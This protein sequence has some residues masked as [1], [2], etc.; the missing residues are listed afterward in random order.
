[1]FTRRLRSFLSTLPLAL[2]LACDGE[3]GDSNDEAAGTEDDSAET[4]T[5]DE[6]E[7]G[8]KTDA[9]TLDDDGPGDFGSDA[10]D[11]GDTGLTGCA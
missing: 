11:D 10:M 2:V 5:G 9:G 3:G 7:T 8:S 1:M 4:E 6:S